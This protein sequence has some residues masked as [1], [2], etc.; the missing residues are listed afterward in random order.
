MK[1]IMV[2]VVVIFAAA[3]ALSSASC[4]GSFFNNVAEVAEATGEPLWNEVGSNVCESMESCDENAF[5]DFVCTNF[6]FTQCVSDVMESMPVGEMPR[7]LT[8]TEKCKSAVVIYELM[9][10]APDLTC[11]SKAANCSAV[12]NC[13][14]GV[15]R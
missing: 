12:A 7:G 10:N 8:C 11:L 5:C 6:N 9:P 3:V 14:S 4:S 15:A 2:A 13:L 1:K